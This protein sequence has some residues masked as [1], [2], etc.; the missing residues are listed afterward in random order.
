M[1]D[2]T[3][4]KK[5]ENDLLALNDPEDQNNDSGPERPGDPPARNCPEPETAGPASIDRKS[6]DSPEHLNPRYRGLYLLGPLP[7][8]R[9]PGQDPFSLTDLD[10]PYPPELEEAIAERASVLAHLEVL[11]SPGKKK[12]DHAQEIQTLLQSLASFDRRLSLRWE[13]LRYNHF[14]LAKSFSQRW[15]DYLNSLNQRHRF[16]A[17]HLVSLKNLTEQTARPGPRNTTW[18]LMKSMLELQEALPEIQDIAGLDIPRS[19]QTAQMRKTAGKFI[20]YLEMERLNVLDQIL[21]TEK[22]LLAAQNAGFSLPAEEPAPVAVPRLT[23]NVALPPKKQGPRLRTVTAVTVV[24]LMLAVALYLFWGRITSDAPPNRPGRILIYNGL[25]ASVT[26]S[27]GSEKPFFLAPESDVLLFRNFEPSQ[28]RTSLTDGLP[29]EDIILKPAPQ[30]DVQTTLIYNIGG[31]APLVEWQGELVKTEPET[32][33]QTTARLLPLGAPRLLY[34][35]AHVF[36]PKFN[37]GQNPVPLWNPAQQAESLF[38]VGAVVGLHPDLVMETLKPSQIARQPL[39]PEVKNLL[40]NQARQSPN[41][42]QWASFWGQRLAEY[43]P[44][45]ALDV[46]LVRQS[47]YPYERW[48]RK[49]L[50]DIS[51]GPTREDLCQENMARLAMDLENIGDQY[52]ITWCLPAEERIPHLKE[53]MEISA[54]DDWLIQALGREEFSTGNYV[55]ACRLWKLVLTNQPSVMAFDLEDLARAEHYLGAEDFEIF[56][57]IN[58]WSPQ[59]GQTLVLEMGFYPSRPDRDLGQEKAYSLLAQGRTEEALAAATG[60][61]RETILTLAAASDG[62]EPDIVLEYLAEAPETGLTRNTAWT[63][64]ALAINNAQDSRKIEEYILANARDRKAAQ[65]VI[66]HL[67]N[68]EPQKIAGL[69]NGLPARAIGEACLAVV[70]TEQDD[71]NCRARAKGFL[72]ITERPYLK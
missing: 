53:A 57:E 36:W 25:S 54:R 64:L 65:G 61:L 19:N 4:D 28:V 18:L 40:V 9:G 1:S 35:R 2:Q 47:L 33:N 70:L 21:V 50:F 24:L 60:P 69:L 63:K 5:N 27:L 6:P 31:A 72:F 42:E 38:S 8:P 43:A 12:A 7:E 17:R 51:D 23:P 15:A 49:I 16:L 71:I 66:E 11:K 48:S 45:E 68:K 32:R 44:E 26:I 59:L 29:I 52:M 22:N 3:F 67:K 14:K 46:M 13:R 10:N 20:E 37:V 34:T 41:W 58:P 30:S 56:D 55:E 62:A 39:D